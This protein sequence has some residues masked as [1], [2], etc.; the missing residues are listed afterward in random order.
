MFD[1][2]AKETTYVLFKVKGTEGA[3]IGLFAD[4]ETNFKGRAFYEFGTGSW[5]N[6]KA[7]FR[8]IGATGTH[9]VDARNTL[10]SSVFLP[11]WISWKDHILSLGTGNKVGENVLLTYDDR[12]TNP[13]AVNYLAFASWSPFHNIFAYNNGK[14]YSSKTI[15]GKLVFHVASNFPS[16]KVQK[17][18]LLGTFS[19]ITKT[20]S[21]I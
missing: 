9:L 12:A 7:L 13:M 16:T 20:S 17:I 6:T 3:N 2:N 5:S 10:N 21:A 8:K 4:I 18:S 15:N 11:Y 1:F 19:L 14:L